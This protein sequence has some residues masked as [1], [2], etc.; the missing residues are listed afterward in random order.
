MKRKILTNIIYIGIFV[1]ISSPLAASE[2]FSPEVAPRPK[3]LMDY[4]H[5]KK[6]GTKVGEHQ[7]T[8]AWATNIGRYGWDDF[9]HTNSFD[10]FFLALEKE[11]ALTI[12][13]SSFTKT[14]LGN[15]DI[16]LIINPDSPSMVPDIPVISDQ[17]ITDL[18]EFVS[19]GGSL[20]VFINSR[21]HDSGK[22]EDVQ[23]RK[24]ANVFGLDWNDDDTKYSN[25]DVGAGHPYFHDID[26]FHYGAGCTMKILP[27]AQD[28]RVLLEVYED[29]GY[30]D[31][32]VDG[33]GIVL[34]RYGKGKMMLVG[35]TGSW[36]ANMSRPWT[37]NER[38][39]RQMFR[40]LKKDNGVKA[41]TVPVGELYQYEVKIA[42]LKSIP[43]LNSLNGIEQP[44]YRMYVPRPKTKIPFFE[45]S[46]VVD[47]QCLNVTNQK[48]R[49]FEVKLAKMN[50]FDSALTVDK[51]ELSVSTNRQGAVEGISS[52]GDLAGWL[53][54]DVSH[55][56][57]FLPND[58]IRIGDRWEK[59]E[60]LRIPTVKGQDAPSVKEVE[61]EM[62]Y[63]RDER[64]DGHDC[65]V[66]RT[67]KVAW[68]PDIG[69][70]LEDILP[71]AEIR[72]IQGQ[73]WE[74]MSGRAGRLLYRREQ[75]IDRNNGVVIRAK[76]QTRI[77]VWTQ[78][79]R[80]AKGISNSEIDNNSVSAH[81]HVVEFQLSNIV[82]N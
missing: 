11:F 19:K 61:V 41:P 53:G 63:L 2:L 49:E 60:R 23:L 68:L 58:G 72:N 36:G 70:A 39:L 14:A 15:T 50:Y 77:V 65:R 38:F 17:E 57:G 80:E 79:L 56:F 8:G 76:A 62:T 32:D 40:Y 1:W 24:L 59:M 81:S 48:A 29:K 71:T 21:G 4:Y 18:T 52:K 6:P 69:V 46:G 67:S 5:H 25:I 3:V 9:A 33:A 78:D 13:D 54:P 37:E 7:I 64:L 55:L 44:H 34:V 22:F 51:N 66:I 30:P 73:N 28:P 26:V 16:V 12:H 35:D 45:A 31:V 47:L 75:W 27:T 74:F 82:I 10:P 20:C 43:T 42:E